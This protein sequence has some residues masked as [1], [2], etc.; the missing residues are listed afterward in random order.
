M[1]NT[2]PMYDQIYPLSIVLS[3]GHACPG[4]RTLPW[5]DIQRERCGSPRGSLVKRRVH[6]VPLL[7]SKNSKKYFDSMRFDAV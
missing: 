5:M 4:P 7:Y 1:V 6:R 2:V 3:Y